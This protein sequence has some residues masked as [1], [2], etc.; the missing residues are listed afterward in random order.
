[1][2]TKRLPRTLKFQAGSNMSDNGTNAKNV[3]AHK[4]VFNCG[5]QNGR[6]HFPGGDVGQYSEASQLLNDIE[7]A[8][9]KASTLH[10]ILYY[11]SHGPK[12]KIPFFEHKGFFKCGPRNDAWKLLEVL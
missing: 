5:L 1:M 9:Q 8:N 12:S 6:W 4:R 2:D 10:R 3:F 7:V 11:E